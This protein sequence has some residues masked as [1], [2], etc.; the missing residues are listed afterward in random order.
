[1]NCNAPPSYEAA[2]AQVASRCP[3]HDERLKLVCIDCN[4]VACTLCKDIGD[5]HQG[6]KFEMLS[7]AAERMRA[8]L[9]AEI[10]H[11]HTLHERASNTLQSVNTVKQS[12]HSN[13]TQEVERPLPEV[14]VLRPLQS[15]SGAHCSTA[16]AK[17]QIEKHFDI[18]QAALHNRKM[19]LFMAVDDLAS[20]KLHRL[21]EQALEL[22]GFKSKISE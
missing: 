14:A 16:A 6:H 20:Q 15:A 19:E 2:A 22:Q 18:L 3:M 7:D 10:D 1:M 4:M 5:K 12:L 9:R 13:G 17:Q 8:H 21:E 11:T